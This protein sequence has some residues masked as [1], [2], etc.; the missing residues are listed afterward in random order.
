MLTI[1]KQSDY[2]L[3]LLSYIYKKREIVS[4]S[5]LIAQTKL[6]KRFLARIAAKLVDEE[7]LVSHEG[8]KGGYQ[9][10]EKLKK[11]TLYAYLK[12]FEENVI[13]CKCGDENHR[14]SYKNICRHKNFLKEKVNNIIVDQLEKIKLFQLID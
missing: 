2:G 3:I 14:C 7:I 10:T 13:I 8:K 4:L 9:T 12:I 1:T 11:I 6:P 5:K